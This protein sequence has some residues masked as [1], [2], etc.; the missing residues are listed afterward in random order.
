[1]IIEQQLLT[2][3][4]FLKDPTFVNKNMF[5]K[6]YFINCRDYEIEV[7]TKIVGITSKEDKN[8][9]VVLKTTIEVSEIIVRF[10][11]DTPK[12]KR[13]VSLTEIDFSI[14]RGIKENPNFVLNES[15]K[16][17]G[18]N[19]DNMYSIKRFRLF[20]SNRNVLKNAKIIVDDE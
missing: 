3:N 15:L 5:V 8:Y 1:M 16:F 13:H 10:F 2:I 6:C 12:E 18:I 20:Y 19:F 17:F 9:N 4:K 11:L 7:K 14:N